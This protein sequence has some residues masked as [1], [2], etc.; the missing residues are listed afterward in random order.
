MQDDKPTTKQDII[1]DSIADGV[2]TVDHDWSITYFNRAAEKITGVS[3]EQAVGQKCYDVFRANIC[4]DRCALRRTME[5]EGPVMNLR[6]DI[7]ACDGHTIPISVCASTLR[8]EAGVIVGG[9]E[10]FRDL[11]DLEML[12]RE[13]RSHYQT[14]DIVSKSPMIRKLLDILPAVSASDCTVLLEGPSGSGKELIARTIHALS[15]RKGKLVAVNIAALPET[16]LESEI[17]GYVK[18]AF[19]GADQDK[20]GRFALAKGGSLLLDEIGDCPPALQVKLLRVLQEKEYEPLGGTASVKTDARIIAATNKPLAGLVA[21]GAFREDLYYRL[22]VAKLSMPALAQRKEDLPLLA[23]HFIR[24]FNALQ[25]K[26]IEG[27]TPEA[28]ALLMAFDYP[29][30]VRQ[31][32]NFFEYAF[33]LCDR[34]LIEPGHLPQDLREGGRGSNTPNKP[35]SS[36]PL[37]E[38]EAEAILGAL[39]THGGNRRQTAAFL[40]IDKATLWRKMKKYNLTV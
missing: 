34:G 24:K 21:R 33:A 31:L 5:G 10:T 20:P 1:L 2:F 6:I 22:N 29:G 9:V 36:R 35:A 28:A 26:E 11:S 18:G 4:Q 30:N 17:F 23:D 25:G 32:E 37:G 3:R 19:T 8:D 12:R 13:I 7:L 38:A 27:V 40:G 16:L 15:G 39:T 14:G